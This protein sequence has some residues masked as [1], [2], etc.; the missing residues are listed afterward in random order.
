MASPA[1]I[2]FDHN[3]PNF[4]YDLYVEMESA[5][6]ESDLKARNAVL[7]KRDCRP[8]IHVPRVVECISWTYGNKA[9]R[10][11][12]AHRIAMTPWPVFNPPIPIPIEPIP[13]TG[14]HGS[15][16]KEWAAIRPKTSTNSAKFFAKNLNDAHNAF[17]ADELTSEEYISEVFG[18]LEDRAS[19]DDVFAF[20]HSIQEKLDAKTFCPVDAKPKFSTRINT[21]WKAY[22]EN[23]GVTVSPDEDQTQGEAIADDPAP[24]IGCKATVS[25]GEKSI[26]AA[27]DNYVAKVPDAETHL[28][29]LSLAYVRR[30]IRSCMSNC[31]EGMDDFED[32]ASHV[33]EKIW[34]SLPTFKGDSLAYFKWLNVTQKNAG[35]DGV[36]KVRR[37]TDSNVPLMVEYEDG[38]LEQNPLIDRQRKQE[39]VRELPDWIQGNNLW[40]CMLLREGMSYAQIAKSRGMTEKAV[41]ECAAKMRKRNLEETKASGAV[42]RIRVR[43]EWIDATSKD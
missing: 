2:P 24:I 34:K 22:R 10:M 39:Y 1:S 29:G 4:S 43:G 41:K 31:A 8:S 18:F 3:H 11:A 7:A 14:N 20:L 25:V 27:Y 15:R 26:R 9:E 5:R 19:S 28:L 21:A 32:V 36:R 30:T 38:E 6:Y 13:Y 40:I 37:E 16:M 35:I 42:K 17:M 33:A 23:N 12:E